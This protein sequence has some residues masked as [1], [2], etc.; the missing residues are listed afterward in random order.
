MAHSIPTQLLN[1]GD[2]WRVTAAGGRFIIELC[3]DRRVQACYDV[4][5]AGRGNTGRAY[6]TS[7]C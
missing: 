4:S 3:A 6:S 2:G 1:R 7:S 5:G